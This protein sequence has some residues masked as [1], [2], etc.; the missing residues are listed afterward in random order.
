M[1]RTGRERMILTIGND[2]RTM[3]KLTALRSGGSLVNWG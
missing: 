1:E 2:L 3:A